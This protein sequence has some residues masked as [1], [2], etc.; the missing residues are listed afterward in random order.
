MSRDESICLAGRV[1]ACANKPYPRTGPS[2]ERNGRNFRALVSFRVSPRARSD[3]DSVSL[4][5]IYV[6]LRYAAARAWKR[7]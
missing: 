1:A 2:R 7:N 4:A 5:V 6:L 3:R